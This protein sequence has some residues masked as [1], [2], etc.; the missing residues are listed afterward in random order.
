MHKIHKNYEALHLKFIKVGSALF[1]T[2]TTLKI[3][4]ESWNEKW[5]KNSVKAYHTVLK[6]NKSSF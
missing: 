5:Y 6:S 1:K 3:V 2:D 4:I